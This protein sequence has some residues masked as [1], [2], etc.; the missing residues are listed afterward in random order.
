MK[1]GRALLLSLGLAQS[2]LGV[3]VWPAKT[4]GLE[5]VIF[6]DHGF[7]DA[8]IG[9]HI[10]Q[11]ADQGRGGP[12]AQIAATW[13]RSCWH[14]MATHRIAEKAGGV[15]ASI[16]FETDRMEN[17]GI[18]F[19]NT[20]LDLYPAYNSRVPFSDLLASA[21]YFALRKCGGPA[22]NVRA[23]RI[24]AHEEG[25][26]GVPDPNEA[27]HVHVNKFARA[28][29]NQT[30]MIMMIACG[31]TIGGV[32]GSDFPTITGNPAQ[33]FTAHF[34]STFNHYDSHIAIDFINDNTT[35]PLA[36]GPLMTR[37]DARVFSSDNN[38]TI[39]RMANL[40]E[41]RSICFDT[42]N[43]MIDTVPANVELSDPITPTWIRPFKPQLSVN[44]DGSIKFDGQIRIHTT[45]IPDGD[46]LK[47]NLLY[48]DRNGKI[49]R[50]N[51]LQTKYLARGFGIDFHF[52]YYDINATIPNGI[53]SFNIEVTDSNNKR[54]V[55]DNAGHGFPM[56]DRVVF[57]QAESCFDPATKTVTV[58]GAVS[59]KI[60]N[61]Q[62]TMSVFDRRP[63]Q[64]SLI[65]RLVK[66]NVRMRRVTGNAPKGY[67]LFR[68][69]YTYTLEEGGEFSIIANAR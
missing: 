11:C 6:N 59:N 51:L 57:Q 10:Q 7:G 62:V 22:L 8:G 21:V 23:G 52:D 54:T 26:F 44:P 41:F 2:S 61:P 63:Q 25:P 45:D 4:D 27:F 66:D 43:R 17:I 20:F 39:T 50:K 5:E 35:N 29:R 55:H 14:D 12:G 24:D 46:N 68:G 1:Q 28:G 38:A 48:A 13:L 19:N 33:P 37:S 16:T 3:Y 9:N 53:S 64:S 40:D 69:Q 18:G 42:F 36:S 56:S 60:R 65:P 34:D 49:G 31:H 67:T 32:H 47:V 58:I 30:E 15:D